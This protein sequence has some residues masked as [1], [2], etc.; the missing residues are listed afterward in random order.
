MKWFAKHKIL[1]AKS[2]GHDA[3]LTRVVKE[4]LLVIKN[5]LRNK[6]INSN[7]EKRFFAMNKNIF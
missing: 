1:Q 4:H 7:S 5:I 3:T 2:K 6:K